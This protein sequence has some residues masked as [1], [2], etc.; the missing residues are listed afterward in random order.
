MLLEESLHSSLPASQG[1]SLIF[2]LACLESLNWGGVLL[3]PEEMTVC[4][5]RPPQ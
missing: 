1:G 5:L 3:F 2:T 4:Y